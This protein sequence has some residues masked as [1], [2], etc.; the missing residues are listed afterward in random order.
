VR[1]FATPD[2]RASV[3]GGIT[4]GV[5]APDG[6]PSRPFTLSSNQGTVNGVASQD[7]LFQGVKVCVPAGGFADVR[8]R[9]PASS[10]IP[11]DLATLATSLEPR[12]GGVFLSQIGL[13]DEIGDR[14]HVRR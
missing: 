9:V 10:A 12:A 13:A 5:R 2:Q 11:G 3:L 6:V 1:V 14:C 4:F 8:L 7:T